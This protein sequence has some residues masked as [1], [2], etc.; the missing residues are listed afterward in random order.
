MIAIN[1]KVFAKLEGWSIIFYNEDNRVVNMVA[2]PV[3]TGRR[4]DVIL[5]EKEARDGGIFTK[6][7]YIFKCGNIAKLKGNKIIISI[8]RG[9]IVIGYI[10]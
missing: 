6:L 2:I 8:N 1:K 10:A 9:K 3:T 7:R 5:E 4:V